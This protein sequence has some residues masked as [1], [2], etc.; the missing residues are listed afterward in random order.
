V[1]RERNLPEVNVEDKDG[2]GDGQS[3]E[4]HGEEQVL[5]QERYR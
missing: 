4:Y 2:D 1:G 5:A 3:D